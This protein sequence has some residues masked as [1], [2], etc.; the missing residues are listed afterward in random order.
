MSDQ[1]T[2]INNVCPASGRPVEPGITANYRGHVV[3]FCSEEHRE[4]LVRSVEYFDQL[5]DQLRSAGEA[6]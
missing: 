4:L 3:G 6:P 2:P 5:I 1:P